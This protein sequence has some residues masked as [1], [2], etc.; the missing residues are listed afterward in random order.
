M[1]TAQK[2]IK[3]F[4]I[5]FAATLSISIIAGIIFGGLGILTATKLIK[6]NSSVE[7]SCEESDK[8]CLQISLAASE[9][10]IKKGDNLSA[11]STYD[12]VEIKQD[13]DQLVITEN[14]G[15]I[16]GNYDRTTIVYVPENMEFDKVG[17]SGGAGR[18][19]VEAIKAKKM[20][21]SLGIGETVFG[22]LEVDQAKIST[23]IGHVEI[24]LASSDDA[25][26]IKVDRGIGEVKFNGSRISSDTWIGNGGKKI[27]ISSGIGE[28]D[29]KT[30]AK[31]AE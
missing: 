27:E 22:N 25:Y 18:I 2:I 13:G 1:N 14:G 16:F 31:K 5:A 23:G 15:S 29:I 20:E 11:E 3:Y 4:A 17:I 21:V 28:L 24:N 9:L 19:Y 10:I 12:K 8:A 26:S 7:I 30:A 6:D